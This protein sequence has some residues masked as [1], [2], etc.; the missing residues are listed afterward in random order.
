MELYDAAKAG[1]VP[2]VEAAIENAKGN[3]YS[4]ICRMTPLFTASCRG[5][6]TVVEQLLKAGAD[7]NKANYN[8]THIWMG[9]TPLYTA[10]CGGHATVVEQLLKAGADVNKANN[11]D[12][13]H[14][15]FSTLY[16]AKYIIDLFNGQRQLKIIS[17]KDH[18]PT[19]GRMT[20]L[21]TASCYG[22]ATVVEQLLAAGADVNKAPTSGSYWEGRTP[23]SVAGESTIKEMLEAAGGR[24]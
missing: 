4:V 10:S 22:H 14:L 6:V 20:P 1:D 13:L 11:D 23:L 12:L 2:G 3:I 21:Y 16:N 17:P 19:E 15:G 8:A 9:W 5:H 7:V 18:W 24:D